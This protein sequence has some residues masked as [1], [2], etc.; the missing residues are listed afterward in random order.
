MINKL[1]AVFINIHNDKTAVSEQRTGRTGRFKKHFH[2]ST[3][4]VKRIR[5][6]CAPVA[7]RLE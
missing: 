5:D 6:A 7:E 4:A 2:P 3:T 1:P